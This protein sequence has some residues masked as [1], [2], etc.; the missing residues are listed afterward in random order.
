MSNH[1]LGAKTKR[2][3]NRIAEPISN[4]KTYDIIMSFLDTILVVKD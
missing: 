3:R 2:K 4:H 1:I